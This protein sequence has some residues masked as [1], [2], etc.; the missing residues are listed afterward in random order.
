LAIAQQIADLLEK[1]SLKDREKAA[2]YLR[3]RLREPE[4]KGD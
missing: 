1:G 2:E 4:E 3:I